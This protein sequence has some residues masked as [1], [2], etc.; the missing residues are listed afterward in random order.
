MRLH[1][2]AGLMTS[3]V[4]PV[5]SQAA[6]RGPLARTALPW[7]AM[8]PQDPDQTLHEVRPRAA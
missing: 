6:V 8:P 2:P 7:A 1:A 4:Y 3:N 5:V